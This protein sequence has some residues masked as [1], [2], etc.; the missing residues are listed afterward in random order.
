LLD[1]SRDRLAGYKR[2][3]SISFFADH[4]TPRAA[5]GKNQHRELRE[6]LNRAGDARE[7]R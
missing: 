1:W 5:T 4:E 6:R 2:P 7:P 3:R